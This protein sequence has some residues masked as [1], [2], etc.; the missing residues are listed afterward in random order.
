M[1]NEKNMEPESERVYMFF[2]VFGVRSTYVN[3][4]CVIKVTDFN[5]ICTRVRQM[6]NFNHIYIYI[7]NTLITFVNQLTN[8]NHI[9]S[10]LI[11]HNHY[12]KS[13]YEVTMSIF[14]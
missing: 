7:Y 6:T 4:T 9:A 13:M 3:N 12:I 8:F 11:T 10:R 5:H 14:Y 1:S 2:F